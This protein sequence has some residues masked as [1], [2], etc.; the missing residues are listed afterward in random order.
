LEKE[1][2][3]IPQARAL[4]NIGATVVAGIYLSQFAFTK[5][6]R[7]LILRRDKGCQG[8]GPHRGRLQASHINH[9]R[10]VEWVN[11]YETGYNDP[12]RGEALCESCHIS[13]HEEFVGDAEAIGL[14]E[15]QNQWAIDTMERRLAN[16]P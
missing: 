11:G 7:R 13:Y 3:T 8:E 6:I 10:K 15:S 5:A 4:F 2:N 9:S 16:E 1:N 14:T 12:R